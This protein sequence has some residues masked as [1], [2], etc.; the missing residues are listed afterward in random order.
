L[1]RNH[2]LAD[3]DHVVEL[4]YNSRLDTFQAVVGNWLIP[5]AAD[6]SEKRIAN[7][8]K[9]DQG[10]LTIPQ[11]RIP[12]RPKD[13][14][15][16]YHLYIVYAEKRDQLLNYCVSKGVEAKI[17]YPI[18]IYRQQAL[19]S[20]VKDLVFPETDYQARNI[21]S[22][23]CDQ[24]LSSAEISEIVQTVGDFYREESNAS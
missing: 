11:I 18:P 16:V 10:L 20:L 3:R 9:L 12:E 5:Q 14:R 24:H 22:F 21:I 19:T 1:L 8:R 17:H 15:V 23:P 4:G 7:A 2:G 6:I 13:M